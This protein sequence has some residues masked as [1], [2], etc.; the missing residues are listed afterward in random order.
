MIW[1]WDTFRV[2][3]VGL[4]LLLTF[5][6]GRYLIGGKDFSYFF[7][8]GTD[9]VDNTQTPT[10]VI[11]QPGQGYDGQFFYRYALN[12]IDFSKTN[13]GVTVDF[14]SYRIQRICYPTLAWIFSFGGTPQLVPFA[15]VLV[16]ILAFLGILIF[17][18]KLIQLTQS[19]IDNLVLPLF[20]FGIYMSVAKDLSEVTELFFYIGALWFYF[21][22][23]FIKFSFFALATLLC[24]ETSLLAFVPLMGY[25]I[26]ASLRAKKLEVKLIW[27]TLPLICFVFW[28]GYI[29]IN[30]PADSAFNG[31][32]NIG[33]PFLGI[34][35]GFIGNLNFSNIKNIFQLTFWILYF[36]WQLWLIK[37]VISF[38]FKSD[39]N[40]SNHLVPL[41]W[42]YVTW[43][44]FSIVLSAAI[45]VDDW[46]FVRVFSLWN[47]TGMLIL[48]L[49]RKNLSFSFQ[50]YSWVVLILTLSRLIIRP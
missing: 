48:I 17:V 44:L 1:K 43:L 33:W 14:V 49:G 34:I 12:P 13:Y 29:V 41:S 21:N 50:F 47:L 37:L 19:S 2:Y 16:N 10:P 26:F 36:I 20:L 9:F 11:V 27:M 22:N 38:L 18:Q 8:A 35:Q 6:S 45:Y 25:E 46:S 40:Q 28:K 5:V 15:L 32:G 4:L 7:V 23:S 3:L 42:I 24:R 31:S 39:F 30:T